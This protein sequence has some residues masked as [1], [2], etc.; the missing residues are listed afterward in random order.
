MHTLAPILIVALL[1]HQPVS[2]AGDSLSRPSAPAGP[3][4]RLGFTRV[5]AFLPGD[6][7][8]GQ[9]PRAVEYSKAYETRLAIHHWASFAT[10]PLFAAEYYIGQKLIN[11]ATRDS[12]WRGPHQAVATG[13]AGLFGVNTITG[14]WNLWDARK[15]PDDRVRRYVHAALMIA[16]DAG[17]VAT[18]A[19]APDDDRF[20]TQPGVAARRHRGIAAASIGT[21]AIG[22]VMMLV[23]K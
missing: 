16:S 1:G 11:D 4:L 21:A 2:V 18:A 19:S 22:Y 13:I 15:D 3:V 10:L 23:W 5:S 7:A 8:Q 17:F 12:R 20:G 9:R 6:G 14:V